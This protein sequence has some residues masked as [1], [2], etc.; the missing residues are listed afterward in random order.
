MHP[1][2]KPV[3]QPKA[4]EPK[5]PCPDAALRQAIHQLRQ[6]LDRLPE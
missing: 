3:A 6:T 4:P 2:P 5:T 1:A